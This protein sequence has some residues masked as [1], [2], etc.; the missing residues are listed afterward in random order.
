MRSMKKRKT[1]SV[2]TSVMNA[3]KTIER[4][5]QSVKN[6]TCQD[7]EYLVIDGGST[8]KTVDIIKIYQTVINYWVSEPD[9]G[10][11]A[12][13]NKGGKKARGDY[14]FFLNGDDWLV[15]EWIMEDIAFI[16]EEKTPDL[17]LGRTCRI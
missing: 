14:L 17:L 1:I 16:L 4:T 13:M 15:N 2:I 12:A 10:L 9:Q 3:E 11:Y 7:L 6:Q 8:D 5:I